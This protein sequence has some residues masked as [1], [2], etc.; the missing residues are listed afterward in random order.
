M[1]G[2]IEVPVV[3]GDVRLGILGLYQLDPNKHFSERDL[4][5][6][7]A[8]GQQAAVAIQNARLFEAEKQRVALL[9]ALHETSLDLRAQLDLP[10]LLRT[11][12]ERAARL[13]DAPMGG[14]YLLEPGG[15][16]LQP[17][18]NL[19]AEEVSNPV[20][21]GEGRVGRVI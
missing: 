21:V 5:L 13:I 1:H 3:T 9:K 4:A 8:V 6:A 20:R 16:I 14:L 17:V 18:A 12:M 15:E 7:E 2:F 11:I 19:P 10:T